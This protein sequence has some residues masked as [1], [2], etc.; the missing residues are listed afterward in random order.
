MHL[1]RT[2]RTN[3]E[4]ANAH[5]ALDFEVWDKLYTELPS[6]QLKVKVKDRTMVRTNDDETKTVLPVALQPALD[7]AMN[8]QKSRKNVHP[9]CFV[10]PS[11]T[12]DA[13]RIY[14]ESKTQAEADALASEVVAVVKKVCNEFDIRIELRSSM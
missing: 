13:V 9:R 6:R 4:S 12:E 10:R 3:I 11:G 8:A 14:A 5:W 1:R 2:D 7:A